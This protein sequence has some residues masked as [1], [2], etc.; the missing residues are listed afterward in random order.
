M[1]STANLHLYIEEE[2]ATAPEDVDKLKG[3]AQSYL[4]LDN[5]ALAVPLLE[6]LLEVQPSAENASNL[7]ETIM[8]AGDNFKAAGVY[9]DAIESDYAG[10]PPSSLL[11]KGL[12]DSLVWGVRTVTPA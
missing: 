12:V 6:R 10:S 1:V 8:A 2:L 5:Y 11:L 7:A 9:R 3:A 4:V